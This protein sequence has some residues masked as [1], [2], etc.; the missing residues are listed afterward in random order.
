MLSQ[1]LKISRRLNKG[2]AQLPSGTQEDVFPQH[3]SIIYINRS[4]TVWQFVGVRAL[5][6]ICAGR[7]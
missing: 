1:L 6:D 3:M 4:D 5:L 7:R 2:S